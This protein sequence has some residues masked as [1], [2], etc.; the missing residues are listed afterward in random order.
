MCVSG[1]GSSSLGQSLTRKLGAQRQVLQ[2]RVIA[3]AAIHHQRAVLQSN[4]RQGSAGCAARVL[5]VEGQGIPS[6]EHKG[7]ALTDRYR[8]EKF[9][10]IG[11]RGAEHA[12]VI[13]V[14]D[15]IT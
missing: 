1:M 9:D 11:V 14:D 10:H 7:H 6:T 12:D 3:A 2:V 15:D 5:G 8:L 13:N 4:G